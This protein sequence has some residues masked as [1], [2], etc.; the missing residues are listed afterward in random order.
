MKPYVPS[1]SPVS[2]IVPGAHVIGQHIIS[3]T[4]T[5]VAA[6]GCYWE[7]RT[8]FDGTFEAIIANDFVST[9]G[10]QIVTI[11]PSDVG[12]Y[13]TDDCGTWVHT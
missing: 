12:F 9:A 6:N 2:T 3:G 5:T 7:R 1:F 13:T 10:S 8:S 11:A 4:Y